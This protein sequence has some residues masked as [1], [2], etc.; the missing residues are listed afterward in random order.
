MNIGGV[1]K[2]RVC[3]YSHQ[4]QISI[5]MILAMAGDKHLCLSEG[6][7]AIRGREVEPRQTSN[8]TQSGFNILVSAYLHLYITTETTLGTIVSICGHKPSWEAAWL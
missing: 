5:N 1:A 2:M 8:K 7:Q 3:L 4:I 6:A